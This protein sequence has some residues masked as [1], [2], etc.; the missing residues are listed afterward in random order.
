MNVISLAVTEH[1]E[2]SRS[3]P[4]WQGLVFYKLA[5]HHNCLDPPHF[6]LTNL[7]SIGCYLCPKD[8]LT[9][10]L[11]QVAVKIFF[12]VALHVFMPPVCVVCDRL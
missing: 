8:T 7:F 12:L 4:L 3:K 1:R 10:S 2:L 6:S 11:V 5:Y 9:F